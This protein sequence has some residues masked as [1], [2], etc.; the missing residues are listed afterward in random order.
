[1][2]YTD[3]LVEFKNYENEEY[4]THR[5]MESVEKKGNV[6]ENI[7]IG[8]SDFSWNTISDDIAILVLKI[9]E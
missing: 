9:G 4:G 8:T 3:G 1:M 5:I 6:I 7:L 2:L